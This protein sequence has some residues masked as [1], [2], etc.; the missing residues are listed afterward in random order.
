MNHRRL[1]VAMLVL[2]GSACSVVVADESPAPK[3]AVDAVPPP[4]KVDLGKQ[5]TLYVVG[6]AHLD[7]EWRWAYPQTIREFIANTLH[8]NF[9][10]FEKYPSYVFNFSGSRRYQMMQEYFPEDYTKLK[11]YVAKGQWFPCG[12][13]V[14]END[15]NVPSAESY[16][17][18][19]LYGNKFFRKEFGLASEEYM[20]PDCFGF[21]AALPSLLSHCGL[22]GFS[23][24]KLTWGLAIGKIPF[25]VGV[26][27]GPDGKSIVAA[28]DPGAY[29][30]EVKENLATSE[31]WAKRIDTNGKSGVFADYHYYG[32]GD[33]GGAPK[34]SSVNMVEKSTKTEGHTK[35]ISGPADWM[36]KTITPEQVAGLP[37]YKGELELTEHSAGSVTSESYMKRW[38]R[39]N[40]LLADSAERAALAAWWAGAGPYPAQRLEDAWTL[41]LGSQMHDILPGTSLPKA[42]EFAWNDEILASNMLADVL[43]R[44]VGAVS[45]GMDTRGTGTSVVIYNPL[46]MDRE[47]VVEM[48]I[49]QP[50]GLGIPVAV[51]PDG[52]STFVQTLTMATEVGGPWKIAFTAKVPGSGYAVY[53]IRLSEKEPAMPAMLKVSTDTLENDRYLVKINSD[54]DVASIFDKSVNKEMLSGAARLGLHFERPKQW[55]AWNQ[56]WADRIKPTRSFVSGPATVTVTESGPVRGAVRVEREHEGSTYVQ[57]IRLAGGRSGDVLNFH[58]HIDWST[59]ER[60]LRAHF[61]LVASNAKATYD[62]QTGVIERP[63][64][65]EKQFE[66]SAHQWMDT[67]DASGA[68]GVSI[69]NDCKY[70][71]DKPDDHTMRLTL[72]YTPGA[73][74]GY[75]DQGTQDL[76][77]HDID[78]AFYSHAG[79]WRAG[80]TPWHAARLNQP[81]VGFVVPKHEGA[82]GKSYSLVS[83]DNP[84]VMVMAAKKAEDS[85]EIVVRL[86]ELTGAAATGVHVKFGMA[87]SAAREIDGQEREIGKAKVAD[88]AL[89]AD[90]H[91]YGLRAFAVTMAKRSGAAAVQ[92]ALS[93]PIVLAF[94]TDVAST[95]AKRSDGSMEG[96]RAYPAE[97]LPAELVVDNITFKLGPTAD[98]KSNALAC[99]G[100]TLTIPGG[101]DRVEILAASSAGDVSAAFKVGEQSTT[102]SVPSWRGYVGQWDNRRWGGTVPELSFQWT[103]PLVGLDPGYVKPESVAWFC[104]HHHAKLA[105]TVEGKE[106][107]EWGD[108]HYQ[109]CYIFRSTIEV[110]AGATKLTLPDMPGVKV[111]AVTAVKG[112]HDHAAPGMPLRDMLTDHSPSAVRISSTGAP[113]DSVQVR[114]DP[115][116]YFGEG[117][118]RY[119]TDGTEPTASSP[120]FGQPFWL[121]KTATVK[122]TSFDSG[123][124]P[125]P[126]ASREVLVSDTT[127]PSVKSAWAEYQAPRIHVEFSEPVARAG[128]IVPGA[129][130]LKATEGAGQE[131][132]MPKAS[133][134]ELAPDARSVV[135][136]VDR[137]LPEN[138]SFTLS[139]GAIVDLAGN[140]MSGVHVPVAASGPIYRLEVADKSHTDAKIQGVKRLPTGGEQ[141]WS[142]N[143]WVKTDRQPADR[144]VIAGF[145]KSD[146][147][148][149]GT[150]RYLTKFSNGIHFW[151]SNADVKGNTPFDVDKWQMI[152]ATFD[153]TTV[154]LYKNAKMIAEQATSLAD[155]EPQVNIL[156]ADP[157]E[158]KRHFA[159]E[160]REFTIWNSCLSEGSLKSLQGSFK[161]P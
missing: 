6:Y 39:K 30:G 7:T 19:I 67:T 124:R 42:Y 3:P 87:A 125:G 24:Q 56:D 79:D 50:E 11:E 31:G 82:M 55:P 78:Y 102:L 62:I 2:A 133:S 48:T 74:G 60:S 107:V 5:P 4:P 118:I 90:V 13:S 40:E 139:F 77:R 130:T 49:P 126:I 63:N 20:L 58:T 98:G 150:G 22:K 68:F 153:G 32:T 47:D 157:W 161:A 127:A 66:Y 141:P 70:G 129:Y 101:V 57:E 72:L 92:P 158:H 109:Y 138:M 41:T 149:V 27:E 154:R 64:S 10:L 132:A 61:P 91:G 54:G 104:S 28:L 21:P 110:P 51:G 145:G 12:S 119:T 38:N 25:N 159:G 148:A 81:L 113:A 108:D 151:S 37:R 69:L 99:K 36:F 95:N 131:S 112:S 134:V 144:T 29:V 85:D 146:D 136:T 88:G 44:S 97:Q 46:G 93:M 65:H 121:G 116:L 33:Q 111:F 16:V 8:D 155:D 89:V 23:T 160:M 137:A 106:V 147:S 128:A 142:M 94:D 26:W 83:C 43:K 96:E 114:V 115:A 84:S 76:G 73:S 143:M 18:H 120:V 122:A 71:S 14:D 34:D 140:G 15:A 45:D 100:Q 59:R 117:S 52:Q 75:Q 80:F 35:V 156:P 1:L 152:T 9:K 53:D 103:N 135:L 123:G 105:R 17:R 86:R